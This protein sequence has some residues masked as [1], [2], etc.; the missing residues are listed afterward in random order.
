VQQFVLAEEKLTGVQRLLLNI[1]DSK[2]IPAHKALELLST[3]L[4]NAV[5]SP[6]THQN[7]ILQNMWNSISHASNKVITKQLDYL[8][9]TLSG[10]LNTY[11]T[12]FLN[13][14]KLQLEHTEQKLA[15]VHPK[16][17]VARGYSLTYKNN[18]AITP[19]TVLEEGDEL[20]TVTSQNTITSKVIQIKNNE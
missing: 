15:L 12:V 17:V 16:N 14:Q 9:V 20:T 5:N 1:N 8:K 3:Q 7:L 4:K 10:T 2:I 11:S 18:K 19:E 13:Q 6:V